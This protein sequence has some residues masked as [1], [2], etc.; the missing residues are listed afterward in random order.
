MAVYNGV[1]PVYACMQ[2][3]CKPACLMHASA[4]ACCETTGVGR[5]GIKPSTC[6]HLHA[7]LSLTHSHCASGCSWLSTQSNILI[8]YTHM[9]PAQSAGQACRPA[10]G[11][12]AGAD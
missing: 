12:R 5:D 11:S 1:N 10:P 6:C 9:C 4:R 7:A 8:F 2:Y 3:S